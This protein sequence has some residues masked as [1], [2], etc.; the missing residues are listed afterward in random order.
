MREIRNYCNKNI[1]LGNFSEVLFCVSRCSQTL[2]A[3]QMG[4]DLRSAPP[5][6]GSPGPFGPGTPEESGKST[7]GQGPKSTQRVLPGVSKESEKSPK[8]DFDSFQTLLRLRGT[9]FGHFW[10]PAPGYSFRTLPGF[11]ARRARETLCGPGAGPI[12]RVDVGRQFAQQ[13]GKENLA[14][15]S[16]RL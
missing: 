14:F 7:L 10:G 12:T 2:K 1:E 15:N 16:T 11:R 8:P 5:H 4:V 6:P 3:V 13:R 9:L